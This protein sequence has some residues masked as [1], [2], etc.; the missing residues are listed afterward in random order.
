MVEIAFSF[1]QKEIPVLPMH[2]SFII[3]RKYSTEL[4]MKMEK[5]FQEFNN[6]FNCKVK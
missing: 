3:E 5:V 2:D 1:C 6:G 4:K